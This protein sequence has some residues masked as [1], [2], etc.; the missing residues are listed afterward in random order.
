MVFGVAFSARSSELDITTFTLP[1]LAEPILT[2]QPLD[3][4]RSK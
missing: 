4:A 1:R 3:K 2:D